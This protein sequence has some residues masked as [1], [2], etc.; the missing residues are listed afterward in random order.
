MAVAR[1]GDEKYKI[2]QTDLAQGCKLQLRYFIPYPNPTLPLNPH[3]FSL[4]TLVSRSNLLTSLLSGRLRMVDFHRRIVPTRGIE[5][6]ILAKDKVKVLEDI[7]MFEKA[8]QVLFSQWGFDRT[9]GSDR[10][11]TVLFYGPVRLLSSSFSPNFSQT[12]DNLSHL[13]LSISYP[14]KGE[15]FDFIFHS[16]ALVRPWRAMRSPFRWVNPSRS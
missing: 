16:P 5:D 14:S 10:G 2:Q 9:M 1:D 4:S 11:T 12:F 8:R 15:A 13:R 6:L 3:A 7:V